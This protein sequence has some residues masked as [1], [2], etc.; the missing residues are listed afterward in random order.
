MGA[1]TA[2]SIV[3]LNKAIYGSIEHCAIGGSAGNGIRVGDPG[4]HYVNAV[5]IEKCTFNHNVDAHILLGTSDGEMIAIRD[6]GFEAG[7]NT[8]AIRGA[9]RA[10]DGNGH[11]LYSPLIEG[12]WAGDN[13]KPPVWIDSLYIAAASYPGTIRSCLF[14]DARRTGKHL[15]LDGPWTVEGCSFQGGTVYSARGGG[16]GGGPPFDS[17]QLTALGNNYG[18]F[19][20]GERIFDAA[21]FPTAHPWPTNYVSLGN[22]APN[23]SPGDSGGA[24]HPSVQP[25]AANRITALHT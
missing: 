14:G 2:R 4:G 1:F 7:T 10:R 11:Q 20:P 18:V 19:R 8:T 17:L 9:T 21:G 25:A 5:Q 16:A 13:T 3:R 15:I 12:C 22:R 23:P 24:Q 6:C